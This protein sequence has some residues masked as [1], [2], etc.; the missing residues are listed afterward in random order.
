MTNEE[1]VERIQRGE[2]GY[3]PTLWEQV[4]RFVRQQAY[5]RSLD[6]DGFGGATFDDLYQSG[7]LALVDAVERYA[8]ERGM[9]FIGFLALRLKTYF[10]EAAGGRTKRKRQ[11]PLQR[12]KSLD[13]PVGENSGDTLSDFVADPEDPYEEAEARIYRGQLRAELDKALGQIPE[14]QRE[15]LELRFFR[16]MSLKAIGEMLGVSVEMARQREAKGLRFLH[17]PRIRRPLEQF[18]ELRTD[19][20]C[21]VGL[22][23]FN[24]TLTSAVE[25]EVLFRE[26]LRAGET[27]PGLSEVS[28]LLNI[29]ESISGQ[30]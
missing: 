25:Q 11:D 29:E 5:G 7:Y 17:K 9:A 16:G 2:T 24:S 27:K 4:E 19:Y 6:L 26:R 18:I 12:A 8:P 14:D 23:R 22:E 1:L 15:T 3:Y 13:K 21:H 30:P 28:A 20:F 10:A